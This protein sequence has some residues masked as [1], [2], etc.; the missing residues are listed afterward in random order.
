M[1]FHRKNPLTSFATILLTLDEEQEKHSTL[2][3]SRR[4]WLGI[5]FA[6]SLKGDIFMNCISLFHLFLSFSQ[7]V[8]ALQQVKSEQKNVRALWCL[9]NGAQ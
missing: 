1:R 7:S 6:V 5:L 3:M 2:K 8:G 9:K 4:A